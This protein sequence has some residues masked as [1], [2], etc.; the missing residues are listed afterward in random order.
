MARN[1]KVV[2]NDNELTPTV[3]GEMTHKKTNVFPIIILFALFISVAYFLPELKLF[4]DSGFDINAVLNPEVEEVAPVIEK[5][6]Y[7]AMNDDEDINENQFTY[8]NNK[9]ISINTTLK[10]MDDDT[11][12]FDFAVSMFQSMN[13]LYNNKSGYSVAF[14]NAD[15]YLEYSLNVILNEVNDEEFDSEDGVLTLVYNEY[16]SIEEVQSDLENDGYVCQV[17]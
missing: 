5:K 8:N 17:N 6:L 9:L 10:I 7:C 4:I 16:S 12:A 1:K 3:I 14:N 2:I 13:D 11:D 15:T